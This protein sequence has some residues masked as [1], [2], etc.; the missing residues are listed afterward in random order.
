MLEI[1]QHLTLKQTQ[2]I[3]LYLILKINT[4]VNINVKP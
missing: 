4:S 3:K 1:N 2:Q